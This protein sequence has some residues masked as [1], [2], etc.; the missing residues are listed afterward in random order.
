MLK[1]G[2]DDIHRLVGPAEDVRR[3][4]QEVHLGKLMPIDEGHGDDESDGEDVV[5]KKGGVTI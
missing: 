2:R 5:S 3:V 1:P 4:L